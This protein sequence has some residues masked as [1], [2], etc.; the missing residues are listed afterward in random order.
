MIELVGNGCSN[1]GS[2]VVCKPKSLTKESFMSSIGLLTAVDDVFSIN[3]LIK[4]ISS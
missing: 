1:N 3:Y 4:L 2:S